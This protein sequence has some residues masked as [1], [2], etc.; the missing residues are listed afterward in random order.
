MFNEI[1]AVGIDRFKQNNAKKPKTSSLSSS[2]E[3][4]LERFFEIDGMQCIA[5]F[6]GY[7]KRVNTAFSKNLGF[8]PDEL[9]AQPLINFVYPEDR[10]ATLAELDN[11]TAGE[12]TISFEN[13]YLTRDG[14]YR[15]LLWT[16]KP[17][18][19]EGMIYAAAR[20][21]TQRK[22]S[23]LALQENEARWQLA[24]KGANDGIW[25]WNVK[26][27]EVFF[28]HRWKEMLGFADD[29]IDNTLEEWSKR[30]HPDDLGWVTETIQAHF[31]RK[32]PFYISEHRLLCKDGSYKW[33]L[34]R[35]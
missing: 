31:A 11:L 10:A 4:D 27:N 29:E 20:D 13:R 17:Y 18:I 12:S 14:R 33:I 8:T 32:T 21:I 19:E 22:Q 24:L 34:D 25:D 3:F 1:A 2:P 9:L 6:D 30:V 35:G 15:W 7:L 16:A 28:S 23:E 26:T 5:G